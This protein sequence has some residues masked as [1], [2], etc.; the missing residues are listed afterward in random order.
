MG[1]HFPPELQLDDILLKIRN[2]QSNK[3]VGRVPQIT[4]KKGTRAYRTATAFEILDQD[5]NHH[6]WTLTLHCIERT[7]IGM[8]FRS[9]AACY[10]RKGRAT[11]TQ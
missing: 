1:V 10:D 5:G 8:D 6:H 4:L 3:N 9:Q 2:A 7:K 11:G